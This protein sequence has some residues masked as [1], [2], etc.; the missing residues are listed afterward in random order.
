MAGFVH[1]TKLAVIGMC[2]ATWFIGGLAAGQVAKENPKAS[3]Q[4]RNGATRNVPSAEEVRSALSRATNLIEGG[5]YDDA[6]QT[7]ETL[8]C[9][10]CDARIS[11]LLAAAFEASGDSSRAQHTLEEA[12]SLWPSNNSIATSLARQYLMVGRADQA[13]EALSSADV[14]ATT[15]PQELALRAQVYL[16]VNRLLDAERVAKIAYKAHPSEES[17]LLLANVLQMQGRAPAVVSFLQGKR[18]QY[19]NSPRFLITLAESEYD[20]A[21]Y[22]AA[23]ADLT[24]AVSLAPASDQAHYL[25]GNTLVKLREVDRAVGEYSTAI[26][27]APRKPRT[28]YSL[29]LALRLLGDDAGAERS[30]RE[31][32]AID[33]QYAPA[34]CELGKLYRREGRLPEA[35]EEFKN[36]IRYNPKFTAAYYHLGVAYREMG[37]R[38]DSE[39]AFKIFRSVKDKEPKERAPIDDQIP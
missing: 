10:R 28:H 18:N 12:H 11:L 1:V 31:S 23:F 24:R 8:S 9:L 14:S 13:A 30:L 29:A 15:P 39:Q 33:I 5:R 27:L 38:S 6:A 4:V 20:D 3:R 34:H 16:A 35:I 17:T 22:E 21:N 25:L 19:Q 2:A 36:A 37:N 26:R 7:L 32:L